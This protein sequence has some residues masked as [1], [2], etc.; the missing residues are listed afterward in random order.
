MRMPRGARHGP[1]ETH[2][3]VHT[4]PASSPPDLVHARSTR[5]PE[6]VLGRHSSP[7]PC[8]LPRYRPV[9]W[10][11]MSYYQTR[12][13]MKK[14]CGLQRAVNLTRPVC[15]SFVPCRKSAAR[16]R[17]TC[18][19]QLLWTSLLIIRR[20]T[21]SV[22]HQIPNKHATALGCAAAQ[23]HMLPRGA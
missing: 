12:P 2:T 8:I 10:V 11:P 20:A 14:Q 7:C 1:D 22:S 18:A 23:P 21:A 15:L 16:A 13:P 5:A 19:C 17:V 4:L 3:R 9:A 6:H